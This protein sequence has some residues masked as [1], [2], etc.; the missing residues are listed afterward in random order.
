MWDSFSLLTQNIGMAWQWALILVITLGSL[1][2]YA[3]DFKLG[4]MIGMFTN[5]MLFML[6]FN[7]ASTWGDQY[8]VTVIILAFMN[9][10]ILSFTLYASTRV[11]ESGGII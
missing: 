6:F 11:A 3:K 10:I 1:I 4:T 5:F 2:F 7:K 9:L 8:W